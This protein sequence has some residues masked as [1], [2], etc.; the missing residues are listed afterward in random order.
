MKKLLIIALSLSI[1]ACST[2]KSDTDQ[3]LE[4]TKSNTSVAQKDESSES[5]HLAEQQTVETTKNL[6]DALQT[7]S[8][9][10]YPDDANLAD[11]DLNNFLQMYAPQKLVKKINNRYNQAVV[12]ENGIVCVFPAGCFDLQNPDDSVQIEL[13]EYKKP[14]DFLL[15]GLGTVSGDRLLET[16]GTAY[17]NATVNGKKVGLKKDYLI[18]FKEA[19][20]PKNDMQLFAGAPEENG[21]IDW[22]L[23]GEVLL[24]D[25]EII[26][27][28]TKIYTSAEITG[29]LPYL[30]EIYTNGSTTNSLKDFRLKNELVSPTEKVFLDIF[31]SLVGGVAKFDIDKIEVSTNSSGR[32]EALYTFKEG[33]LKNNSIN[34]MLDDYLVKRHLMGA[35]VLPNVKMVFK[36]TDKPTYPVRK[37][38]DVTEDVRFQVIQSNTYR[39]QKLGWINC[40]RFPQKSKRETTQ[41][42]FSLPNIKSAKVQLYFPSLYSF[43][44]LTQK[45]DQF[46]SPNIA[47]NESVKVV[48]FGINDK[49]EKVMSCQEVKMTGKKP[50]VIN[51]FVPFSKKQLMKDLDS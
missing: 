10:A 11:K 22:D 6:E 30:T 32:Y 43:L 4:N 13:I 31:D 50:I 12:G 9:R 46:V 16:G 28:V 36:V 15:S 14:T 1:F 41:I 47:K 45:N 29:V 37:I 39:T 38:V 42:A 19:K 44:P 27:E 18:A 3:T 26:K 21:Q 5:T 20:Q 25:K 34:Q 40:D 7:T 23:S 49:N 8:L 24:T 2:N 51:K 33:K 17:L 48:V 35:G